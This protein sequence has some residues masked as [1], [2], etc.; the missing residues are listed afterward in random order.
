MTQKETLM[1]RH[2]NFSAG[3]AA[4]PEE[5][6]IQARD[7]LLDWH[8]VGASVMEISHRGKDFMEMAATAEQDLRDLLS[9]PKNYHVLFLQNGAR[10]QFAMVPL[11]LLGN[12]K[13]ADYVDT[14]IWSKIAIAEAQRYCDVNV[15]TSSEKNNYTTI[16]EQN[17]WKLNSDAAYFHYVS[18]ETVNGIEFPYVPSVGK[19]P[20]VA[21]MSSNILSRPIDVEQYGLIYAGAQ[22]NIGPSGLTV[23]IVRDDLITNPLPFTPTVL[24]YQ[25]HAENNSLYNTPPTFAWYLASLIFKW[26]KRQGGV[27][28][29]AKI[30]QQKAKMLYDY[31]DHSN[32]YYNKIETQYRSRMNVIFNLPDAELDA[33]FLEEAKAA[34]LIGLKGHKLVGGMRASIYNAVPEKAVVKLVEFMDS[35]S[36][37]H[38]ITG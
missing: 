17:H 6:L 20:L 2:Y 11:N 35:F 32:F 23:V 8:H 10:L 16:A 15:V 29:M 3:P 19:V 36:I 9:I 34:G 30:N 21:D 33:V 4:L 28:A 14:G 25:V 24:R 18:N 7:E 27:D 5:V 1:S 37:K 22:K 31:I 26:L 13:N 38:K 12:K